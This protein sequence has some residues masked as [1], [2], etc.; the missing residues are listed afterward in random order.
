MKKTLL[1]AI[2]MLVGSFI[3]MFSQPD[4]KPSVEWHGF[5]K[6][7]IIYDTR[8]LT[9][10]REGHFHIIPLSESLDA[11]GNDINANPS[12]NILSIQTRLNGKIAGPEFAGI[13]TSGFLEGEFFG[14]TDGDGNG[15][16]L[17]HAFIDLDW[18]STQLRV[19]QFWHP[20]FVTDCF[21][22][23]VNF[24]TG[25]PFQPFSRN[26]QIRLTQ[27]FGGFSLL[28]TALSQRDFQ[29]Y[30]PVWDVTK[31]QYSSALSTEYARNSVI[32]EVHFQLKYKNDYLLIGAGTGYKV[33]RPQLIT[34]MS[35]TLGNGKPFINENTIG[36]F[37]AQGFMK[38]TFNSITVKMEGT[39]GQNMA[40]YTMIGG[41]A[42]KS[43]NTS[44]GVLDYTNNKVFSG[45][46]D[47][48]FKALE[49]LSLNLFG[50]YSKNLGFDDNILNNNLDKFPKNSQFFTRAANADN[51][52]RVSPYL[53][54]SLGKVQIA[55]EVEYTSIAFGTNDLADKGKVIKAK[56]V[57]NTRSL[58]AVYINF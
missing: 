5:V 44:T 2:I 52:L 23:V 26:P 57:A 51:V 4:Y 40:N 19:G 8:Q 55:G 37:N 7:D 1:L 25:A 28:L 9:A 34:S 36:S 58:L 49:N 30:G 3:S 11:E 38:I 20:M 6:T 12:F 21:A 24:N 46:I 31:S 13:K 56:K 29:S 41:Y 22:D 27:N 43:Y 14:T 15:F 47:I 33:L 16:R 18:S 48:N 17:R 42:V 35:D 32:P 53:R 39:Y 45:W 54:W 10:L 50:G